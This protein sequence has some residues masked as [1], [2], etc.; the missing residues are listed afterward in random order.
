MKIVV[1][2]P[3]HS[4]KSTFTASLISTIRERLDS[5]RYNPAFTWAPL[6]VTDNTLAALLDD[7]PD[8]SHKRD[9]EF[10][11]ERA[12]ERRSVF[13]A[14]DESIVLGDSPGLITEELRIVTEP[15]DAMI[16]LVSREKSEKIGE[17]RRFARKQGIQLYAEFVTVISDEFDAQWLDRDSRQGII[18]SVG[19]GEFS[20][21]GVESLDSTSRRILKQ[22]AVDLLE[23]ADEFVEERERPD[24]LD[25]AISE[26]HDGDD[27]GHE[28]DGDIEFERS[29]TD[30]RS[31]GQS[32]RKNEDSDDAE[33][34]ED[35]Q[36]DTDL[37]EFETADEEST[38]E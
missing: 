30:S 27:A 32:S 23:S 20:G 12:E 18:E 15:A 26:M 19:R 36:Q 35:S 5:R 13:A 4:G 22:L 29:H 33:P 28:S 6:D 17:W 21:Q 16:L 14:R 31:D 7:G 3:P 11:T 2:G 24:A 10:T 34:A 9:V 8:E 25:E 38:E 37:T 1:C